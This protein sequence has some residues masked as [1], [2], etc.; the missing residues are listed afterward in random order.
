M[1]RPGKWPGYLAAALLGAGA[2][3]WRVDPPPVPVPVVNVQVFDVRRFAIADAMEQGLPPDL[4]LSTGERESEFRNKHSRTD[5]H[6]PMQLHRPF[7]P[8]VLCWSDTQNVHEGNRLLARYWQ[9]TGSRWWSYRAY[10]FGPSVLAHFH[11]QR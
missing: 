5:D 9:R 2:A 8:D 7:Y 3:L 1:L 11:R 6:G 4:A 10:Q